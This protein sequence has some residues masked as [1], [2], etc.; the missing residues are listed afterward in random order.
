MRNNMGD[1]AG[2]V[3]FSGCEHGERG[4]CEPCGIATLSRLVSRQCRGAVSFTVSIGENSAN[5][6]RFTAPDGTLLG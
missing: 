6:G 3:S 1:G 5:V 2:K 4:Y